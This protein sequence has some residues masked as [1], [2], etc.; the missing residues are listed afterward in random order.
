[1]F[2]CGVGC[3]CSAEMRYRDRCCF[4]VETWIVSPGR[5]EVLTSCVEDGLKPP[6]SVFF[7]YGY[8]EISHGDVLGPRF[9]ESTMHVERYH[10]ASRLNA[11][12]L[13]VYP[14]FL[15]ETECVFG[16]TINI[17]VNHVLHVHSH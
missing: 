11:F 16:H 3:S 9:G 5:S 2:E 6:T 10:S 7:E 13:I 15:A 14:S 1:M 12:E 4:E 8:S 17:V